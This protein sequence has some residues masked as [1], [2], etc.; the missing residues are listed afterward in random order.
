MEL[1]TQGQPGK[2]SEQAI[3]EGER[4]EARRAK[5][6]AFTPRL[7]SRQPFPTEA[8]NHTAIRTYNSFSICSSV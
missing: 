8:R 1:S 3:A 4:I 2:R 7:G 5:T 6:L